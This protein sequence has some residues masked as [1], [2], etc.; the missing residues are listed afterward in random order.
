MLR[1]F[2]KKKIKILVV[3]H[4]KYEL[5]NKNEVYVPI[6][7]GRKIAD[8][9]YENNRITKQE[10]DWL[11]KNLVGDN[12]GD[13]ISEL[14]SQINEMTAIYWAWKNY[15]K[16]DN[17]DYIGLYHY[18]RYLDINIKDLQNIFNT[19]YYAQVEQLQV[20]PGRTLYEQWHEECA[21]WADN[22]YLDNALDACKNFDKDLGKNIEMFF[23]QQ[24]KVSWCNM[25]ILPKEEFFKYCE[26]IFPLLFYLL[27]TLPKREDRALGMFAERLTAY[28]LYRLSISR[29]S[30]STTRIT[31][32]ISTTFLQNIF[33]ITNINNHK[34]ILI[35]GLKI[36]IKIQKKR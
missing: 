22:Q 13:N 18:R 6:H 4:K 12:T 15:D 33:S 35:L 34:Q 26:F 3:Y 25:F 30:Y 31:P 27:D 21:N 36:K 17:P 32:A 19:Y 28:Y 5:P 1:H 14:N 16:L 20:E 10:Y 8:Y 2:S 24:T 7:A 11:N 23:K 29:L 9:N